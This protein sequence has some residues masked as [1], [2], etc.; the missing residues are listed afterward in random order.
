MGVFIYCYTATGKSTLGRKFANVVDMESTRYKYGEQIENE[1]KKGT[2]RVV[3]PDYPNNYFKALEA[4][5]D[6][7][8]YILISDSI[9]NEW[10]SQNNTEYWQVYPEID[11]KEEYLLRMKNRGNN[12]AFIDY[13]SYMWDEWIEG[14]QNDPNAARHIVLKTGQYLEDVLPNLTLKEI[15]C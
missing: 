8:D 1:Q 6:L 10:L 3:N 15:E 11:L 9:C 2:K 14:C 13:Q 12:Q 7:Y 5:K 4:V